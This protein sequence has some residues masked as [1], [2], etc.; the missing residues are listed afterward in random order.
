M[1]G[2]GRIGSGSSLRTSGRMQ[3][4]S[5][6]AAATDISG[7]PRAA[8]ASQFPT[9][10]SSS[11]AAAT[12]INHNNNT[13]VQIRSSISSV[14]VTAAAAAG[15]S[16]LRNPLPPPSF[17]RHRYGYDSS[18]SRTIINNN[19]NSS[20]N[21]SSN[22][23]GNGGNGEMVA[24]P[25]TRSL[26]QQSLNNANYYSLTN[27]TTV[28]VP[29]IPISSYAI[30]PAIIPSS[31]TSLSLSSHGRVSQPAATATAVSSTATSMVASSMYMPLPTYVHGVLSDAEMKQ[32]SM[33]V[34]RASIRRQR[35]R[36][37]RALPRHT[38]RS[39]LAAKPDRVHKVFV[40]AFIYHHSYCCIH[41]IYY[42]NGMIQLYR[43]IFVVQ[44][45]Y[46][47]YQCI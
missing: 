17:G 31:S 39:P 8:G 47:L 18:T 13:P 2:S 15:E 11:L 4:G 19:T 30:T 40:I 3:L 36:A 37:H 25:A 1:S 42:D 38:F 43:C 26:R 45:Y 23:Y 34:A 20:I 29:A 28:A 32:H 44:V 7:Y 33:R 16:L 9:S 35:R 21:N 5:N 14:A 41:I 24:I 46:L 6:A 10:V 22:T 27:N 12:I